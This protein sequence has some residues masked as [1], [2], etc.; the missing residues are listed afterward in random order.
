MKFRK[1][2]MILSIMT[3]L[4]IFS[5]SPAMAAGVADGVLIG[6]STGEVVSAPTAVDPMIRTDFEDGMYIL[7][8]KLAPTLGMCIKDNSV[9]AG[10]NV[11]LGGD[12]GIPGKVFKVQRIP[13]TSRYT[14]TNRNSGMSIEWD[15]LVTEVD[16]TASPASFVTQQPV[17]GEMNQ[18]WVIEEI[19]SG[20][21]QIRACGQKMVLD[22]ANGLFDEVTDIRV[23]QANQTDAQKW[24]LV[25]VNVGD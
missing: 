2:C 16:E 22:L 15:P 14:F 5:A 20:Y 25:K 18:Q 6:E 10:G 4:T 9:D 13:N 3:C 24:M 17:T 7:V 12:N 11:E 19:D 21:L 23:Y 1:L 8:P